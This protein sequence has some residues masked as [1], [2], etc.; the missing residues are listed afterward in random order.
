MARR[1]RKF[2][3]G[4]GVAVTSQRRTGSGAQ[5]NPSGKSGDEIMDLSRKHNRDAL[6]EKDDE[7]YKKKKKLSSGLAKA[8]GNADAQELYRDVGYKDKDTNFRK[9]GLVKAKKPASKK[10]R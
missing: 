7:E 5:I 9:G 1:V 3:E 4:G 2:A 8:A 6:Y 10:K